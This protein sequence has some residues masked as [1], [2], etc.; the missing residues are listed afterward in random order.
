MPLVE[1]D[2][3]GPPAVVLSANA[4]LELEACRNRHPRFQDVYAGWL[5]RIARD[6]EAGIPLS[7]R[8]PE[9]LGPGELR[10][11][12]SKL[13]RNLPTVTLIF[14]RGAE[15]VTVLRVMSSQPGH[16]PVL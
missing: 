5:W 11:V 16:D 9:T 3:G 14:H 6:K 8:G 13:S 15:R 10:L 2:A 12:K 1:E 7:L 4:A